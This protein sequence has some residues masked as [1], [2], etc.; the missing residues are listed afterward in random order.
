MRITLLLVLVVLS[1]CSSKPQ[2]S[3][4]ESSEEV[5]LPIEKRI[6]L[7]DL[8]GNRVPLSAFAGK[9]VFVNF[10]AS[11]CKPCIKEM[12]SISAANETLAGDDFVFLIV[13]DDAVDKIKKFKAKHDFSFTYYHLEIP[14]YE[15]DLKALPT[16]MV[17]NKEGKVVFNEVGARDWNSDESLA[18]LRGLKDKSI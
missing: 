3:N 16:T 1:A 17:L 12:P 14:A 2:T 10:W 9:T 5:I 6:K 15:L 7:T 8:E 18:L 11:W 13:T 4:G